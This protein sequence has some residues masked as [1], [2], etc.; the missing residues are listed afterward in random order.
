MGQQ[1]LGS[2]FEEQPVEGRN[3]ERNHRY[4]EGDHE[5]S[6][7]RV[8]V[9]KRGRN[10]TGQYTRT[11]HKPRQVRINQPTPDEPPIA[12]SECRVFDYLRPR[13]EPPNSTI[14]AGDDYE[15]E[16]SMTE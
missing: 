8:E 4:V 15:K 9:V 14:S 10:R 16:P 13:S 1:T 3:P 2:V 5:W 7:S 12:L 11:H 6:I